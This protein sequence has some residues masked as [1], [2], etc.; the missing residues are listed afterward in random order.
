MCHGAHSGPTLALYVHAAPQQ[1]P[2]QETQVTTRGQTRKVNISEK[3]SIWYKVVKYRRHCDAVGTLRIEYGRCGVEPSSCV[4]ASN[5][6]RVGKTENTNQ[7]RR[8]AGTLNPMPN[9]TKARTCNHGLS[10]DIFSSSHAEIA[11][12]QMRCQ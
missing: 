3:K 7:Y 12:R 2:K 6:A 11:E 8:T 5:R 9:K 1:G 10:I 4:V